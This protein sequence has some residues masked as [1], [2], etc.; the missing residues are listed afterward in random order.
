MDKCMVVRTHRNLALLLTGLPGVTAYLI[1][2]SRRFPRLRPLLY[3]LVDV[4]V[5]A[6]HPYVILT[7][8][9]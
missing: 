3:G 8:Q 4:F 1:W 6:N 2:F 9:P 5:R 7:V